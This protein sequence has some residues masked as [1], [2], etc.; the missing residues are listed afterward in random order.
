MIQWT[1]LWAATAFLVVKLSYAG[2]VFD[3]VPPSISMGLSSSLELK[4]MFTKDFNYNMD[5]LQSI[6]ILYS[7]SEKY[8]V[9][10]LVADIN[11]NDNIARPS[12]TDGS[13]MGFID[14]DGISYLRVTFSRPVK[15]KAGKYQCKLSGLGSSNQVQELKAEVTVTEQ[16]PSIQSVVEELINLAKH[17][18]TL[19]NLLMDH[20]TF[21]RSKMD[22]AASLRTQFYISEEFRSHRYY[23]YTKAQYFTSND[24]H[25][26]CHM[27]G[28][29]LA[30]INDAEEFNFVR[31][32]IK[33]KGAKFYEVVIG[34]SDE[35]QE[36]KWVYPYSNTTATY[37]NFTAGQPDGG[38]GANDLC[39][40]RDGNYLM[41]DCYPTLSSAWTF[42]CEIPSMFVEL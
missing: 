23:M 33:E 16:V 21:E 40:W 3:A 22:V 12:N 11:W 10:K 5:R 14:K 25:F 8:P 9:W 41:S 20:L 4:C 6:Q 34:G 38:R 1:L 18:E 42:L 7:A 24:A 31:N 15:D 19:K 17:V 2:L 35:D 37:L 27:Y 26:H 13:V 36:G 30:E 39:Y 32:F 28:G 29:Y